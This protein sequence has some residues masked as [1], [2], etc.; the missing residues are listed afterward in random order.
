LRKAE[1]AMVGRLIQGDAC[2]AEGAAWLA[3]HDPRFAYAL[4]LTGPLP[5]RLKPDGFGALL[6]AIIGQQVST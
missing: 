1:V 3:A 2:V 4:T 6:D 5:L